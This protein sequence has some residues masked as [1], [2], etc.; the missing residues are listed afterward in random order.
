MPRPKSKPNATPDELELRLRTIA[1]CGSVNGA[2]TKL[3]MAE[4]TL[5][6]VA[7]ANAE[8][9]AKIREEMARARETRTAAIAHALC[10]DLDAARIRLRQIV[11]DST[12]ASEVARAAAELTKLAS[13][14]D[15][16]DRLNHDRPTAIT[17][18]S[19]TPRAELES[20]RERLL[21]KLAADPQGRAAMNAALKGVQ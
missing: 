14:L 2:A 11:N 20:E 10:D 21:S 16:Q 13:T 8:R 5:R 4:S 19:D 15:S 9:L 18:D 6:H 7:E 1:E 3:K 12:D 17:N